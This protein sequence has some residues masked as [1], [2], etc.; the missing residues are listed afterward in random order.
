MCLKVHVL[1]AIAFIG[2][3]ISR[4]ILSI[5]IFLEEDKVGNCLMIMLLNI[6]GIVYLLWQ[7]ETIM[8]NRRRRFFV[9]LSR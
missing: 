3:Q 6:N 5:M 9:Y 7:E 2:R 8:L 1:G 4:G